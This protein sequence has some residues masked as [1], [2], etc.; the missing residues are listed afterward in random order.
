MFRTWQFSAGVM[1]TF[2]LSAC[3][4]T[5]PWRQAEYNHLKPLN[6]DEQAASIAAGLRQTH[7]HAK[8]VDKYALAAQWTPQQM[9]ER[10]KALAIRG[11]PLSVV[12]NDQYDHLTSQPELLNKFFDGRPDFRDYIAYSKLAVMARAAE[13]PDQSGIF[14]LD[15]LHR[16]R[17]LDPP[18]MIAV[19]NL[20]QQ[21]FG[22][23][24]DAQAHKLRDGQ[25]CLF[26]LSQTYTD[27][28]RADPLNTELQ[29]PSVMMESYPRFCEQENGSYSYTQSGK[30]EPLLFRDDI[31]T[32]SPPIEKHT[33]RP[34][35]LPRTNNIAMRGEWDI[36]IIND[37]KFGE[38]YGTLS[39]TQNIID[40]IMP[41][42]P[43]IY[44]GYSV[45]DGRLV[46]DYSGR[47]IEDQLNAY[48]KSCL[49]TPGHSLAK[50]LLSGTFYGD[51]KTIWFDGPHIS[52]IA[53]RADRTSLKYGG[54]KYLAV[55]ACLLDHP[56]IGA[57]KYAGFGW[58]NRVPNHQIQFSLTKDGEKYWNDCK[59]DYPIEVATVK[60][61]L[62]FL[63]A[64]LQTVKA[65][66]KPYDSQF[67]TGGWVQQ[68]LNAIV[69][70]I[71]PDW[72]KDNQEIIKRLEEKH[73]Y[74]EWRE[75]LP[76][77]EII[78]TAH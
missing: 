24:K 12:H 9:I 59:P 64:K 38:P 36:L 32:L 47:Y 78:V 43:N 45:V 10:A 62:A 74:I 72:A 19:S 28:R 21:H 40:L 22:V 77:D 29:D 51:R 8:H 2:G 60:Y 58:F 34:T 56:N 11:V 55:E 39:V 65:D 4:L 52:F 26:F 50:S 41:C 67:I 7:V 42:R 66:I 37:D 49:N 16:F 76:F 14:D 48:G 25:V 5:D 57:N 61:S 1:L 63:E 13:R 23:I 20:D 53:K 68:Q 35:H 69:V 30:G 54:S 17:G 70:S 31:L 75:D 18:L 3:A 73:P 6:L 33:Q 27:Y 44:G 46:S 15:V 71:D